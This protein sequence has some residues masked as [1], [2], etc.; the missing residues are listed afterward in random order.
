MSDQKTEQA[1][2]RRLEK[3]REE[4]N[5][6][7]SA[8]LL[9]ALYLVTAIAIWTQQGGRVWAALEQ[10]I[11]R[12]I[13]TAFRTDLSPLQAV[14]EVLVPALPVAGFMA[15][16]GGALIV[17]AIALQLGQTGFSLAPSRLAPDLNRLN[18]FPKLAQMPGQNAQQAFRALLLLPI[19]GLL[20]EAL[21]KRNWFEI[22]SLSGMA[23]T[24]AAAKLVTLIRSVLWQSAAVL[25]CIALFDLFQKR[26]KYSN[27]MMMSRQEVRDENKDME[28]NVQAKAQVRR[29]MRDLSRRRMM[30]DV[31]KATA[32]IVNPTHYA[33]AIYYSAEEGPAPKVL[34]KGKNFLAARIRA[35]ALSNGVPIVENPPLARSLYRSAEIGQEIPPA[36]YRAVAEVLAY[37]YRLTNGGFAR[38]R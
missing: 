11:R 9:A 4:G 28:G 19:L 13:E 7:V 1:T 38:G 31:P 37:V 6:P 27:D 16:A 5:F 26:R 23:R 14:R 33:V 35:L 12:G 20:L 15:L 29:M 8:E 24:E 10:Q 21:V 22:L 32:V 2:P 36:L 17:I 34:A 3:A 25:T 30:S 18:P